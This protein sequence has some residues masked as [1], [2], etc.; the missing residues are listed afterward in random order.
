MLV[1]QGHKGP[2]AQKDRLGHKALLVL[3]ARQDRKGQLAQ[4]VRLVRKDRKARL[5]RLVLTPP[6][7][8]QRVRQVQQATLRLLFTNNIMPLF[9][10]TL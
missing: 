9:L 1:R 10:G 2:L 8:G 4:Q 5:V 3:K 6:F 7:R